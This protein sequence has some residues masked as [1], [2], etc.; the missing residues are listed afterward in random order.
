LQ[1]E[2]CICQPAAFWRARVAEVVG[3]F[4]ESLRYAMDYEY[5]LR[6]ARAGA[7][8]HYVDRVLAATRRHPA[9]KSL[10]ERGEVL[11]EII[12]VSEAQSHYVGRTYFIGLWHHRL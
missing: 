4:N 6:L 9:T 11:R 3:P 10:S 12:A 2:N 7:R 1:E 5:W 8:F